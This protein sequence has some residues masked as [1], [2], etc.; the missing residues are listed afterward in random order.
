MAAV[1]PAAFASLRQR[2]WDIKKEPLIGIAQAFGGSLGT[3]SYWVTPNAKDIETQSKS[4]CEHGATGLTFYAWNNSG[5]GPT[6]PMPMNSPEIEM[7]IRNGI[8]V[9]EQY[10][11]TR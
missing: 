10:W 8:A 9:C 2:G 5:F 3:G 7:G 6:T 11:S 4:F 1:L